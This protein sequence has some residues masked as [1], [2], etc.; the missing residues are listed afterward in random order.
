LGT[1]EPVIAGSDVP[2]PADPVEPGGFAEAPGAADPGGFAERPAT[3]VRAA[4][5][6]RDRRGEGFAGV[7]GDLLSSGESVAIVCADVERRRPGL[8]QV[9][10]G[11]V[12]AVAERGEATP[13][14]ACPSLLS[15]TSLAADPSAASEFTHLVALDPPAT[16]AEQALLAAAPAPPGGFAHLA[17]SAAEAEFALGVARRDLDL[18]PTVTAIYRELRDAGPCAGRQLEALLRGPGPHARP[19]ALCARA[20]RVLV[21]V[22]LVAFEPA[23]AGGYSARVLEAGRTDLDRSATFRACAERLAEATAFIAAE[24]AQ[25]QQRA[26]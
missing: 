13:D 16:A 6:L 23:P 18:R 9:V 3:A 12:H 19:P 22:G 10:A 20:T 25:A 21:E 2:E 14:P 15:W 17:W 4:R 1:L 5:T 26:A 24:A 7:A 8:E 11:I